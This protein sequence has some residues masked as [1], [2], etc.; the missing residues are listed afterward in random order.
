MI[1]L[2]D[3]VEG[4]KVTLSD[5]RV[6]TPK[7]VERFSENGNHGIDVYRY[8]LDSETPT[9]MNI[10]LDTSDPDVDSYTVPD[11]YGEDIEH[12]YGWEG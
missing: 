1:Q 7:L 10:G 2:D 9:V 8:C 11:N 12:H 4:E 6:F 5:G 3:G